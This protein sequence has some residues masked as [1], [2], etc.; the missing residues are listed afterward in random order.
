MSK[1]NLTMDT[2]VMEGEGEGHVDRGVVMNE[3]D[4]TVNLLSLGYMGTR[5]WRIKRY[6]PAGIPIK[7]YEMPHEP[8]RFSPRG[9]P[10]TGKLSAPIWRIGYIHA[11]IHTCTHVCYFDDANC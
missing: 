9:G 1:L 11:Y 5:G 8:E 6:N 3:G 2:S 7:V 10:N 4:G